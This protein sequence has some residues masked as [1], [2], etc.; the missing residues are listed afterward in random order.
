MA[1]VA[2][3]I[4][5]LV[6]PLDLFA[7]PLTAPWAPEGG[8]LWLS[9]M[10]LVIGFA[11]R[12]PGSLLAFLSVLCPVLAAVAVVVFTLLV[13]LIILVVVMASTLAV[14]VIVSPVIR[15]GFLLLMSTIVVL[16]LL[17]VTSFVVAGLRFSLFPRGSHYRNA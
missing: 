2:L 16:L 10:C 3:V 15:C 5:L 4:M 8:P 9:L 14:A 13:P 17:L 12:F 1:T 11:L 7:L 6:D